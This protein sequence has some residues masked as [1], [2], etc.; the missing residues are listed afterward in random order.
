M[1]KCFESPMVKELRSQRDSMVWQPFLKDV[2]TDDVLEIKLEES[3]S[4]FASCVW[5]S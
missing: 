2:I 3:A 5:R 1:S 4:T